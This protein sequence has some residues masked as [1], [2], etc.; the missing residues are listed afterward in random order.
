MTISVTAIG[1]PQARRLG[2][3]LVLVATFAASA[4]GLAAGSDSD[5]KEPVYRTKAVEVKTAFDPSNTRVAILP[6]ANEALPSMKD[7]EKKEITENLDLCFKFISEGFSKRGFRVIPAGEIP[8]DPRKALSGENG[9]EQIAKAAKAD[10]VIDCGIEKQ[11]SGTKSDLGTIILFG[12]FAKKK[13]AHAGVRMVIW[14]PKEGILLSDR[15]ECTTSRL[16]GHA[17]AKRHSLERSVEP[18]L[19]GLLKPYP[20]SG[21]GRPTAQHSVEKAAAADATENKVPVQRVEVA[22]KKPEPPPV[23]E[24]HVPE[25]TPV[26]SEVRNGPAY[27]TVNGTGMVPLRAIGEWMGGKIEFDRAALVVNLKVDNATVSLQ[28]NSKTASI[29]GKLVQ[30]QTAPIERGGVTYVP[31]RVV[32]D[33]FSAKITID[34]TTGALTVHHPSSAKVLVLPKG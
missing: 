34:A 13:V 20:I 17:A 11:V 27:L 26:Q 6:V 10:L 22:E 9:M 4:S 18:A 29:N 33:A 5:A 23:V 3:A 12:P 31:L 2:V 21:K 30:L 16:R 24:P 25:P 19:D 7:F 1:R 15:F 8:S 28:L 32:S 14:S